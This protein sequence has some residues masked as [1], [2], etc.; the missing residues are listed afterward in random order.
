MSL[1]QFATT[2]P[3]GEYSATH[4]VR[5]YSDYRVKVRD[6]DTPRG[7]LP[8]LQRADIIRPYKLLRTC[9]SHSFPQGDFL[10]SLTVRDYER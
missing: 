10:A 8:Q 6:Y 4:R 7:T 9:R 1:T 2:K 5:G 3:Q